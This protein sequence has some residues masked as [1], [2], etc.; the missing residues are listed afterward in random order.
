MVPYVKMVLDSIPD[1]MK[2]K[3]ATPAAKYLYQINEQPVALNVDTA[4]MFHLMIMQLYYL[5]Q[6]GHPDILQAVSFLS[7]RMQ[8]PDMDDYKKLA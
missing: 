6:R 5:A 4:D 1:D 7:S 3:A 8:A 2:G